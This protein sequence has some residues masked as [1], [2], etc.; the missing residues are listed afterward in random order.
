MILRD[1]IQIKKQLL[2]DLDAERAAVVRKSI[3]GFFDRDDDGDADPGVL[4]AEYMQSWS[5]L[6]TLKDKASK[7]KEE[8][9]KNLPFGSS[10]NARDETA[11]SETTNLV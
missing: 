8:F 7:V 9:K 11:P 3:A 1:S 2:K 6:N 10:P 4:K 5:A